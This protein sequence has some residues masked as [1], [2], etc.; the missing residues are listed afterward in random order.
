M[1]NRSFQGEQGMRILRSSGTIEHPAKIAHRRENRFRSV[2]ARGRWWAGLILAIAAAGA[3]WYRAEGRALVLPW[4]RASFPPGRTVRNALPTLLFEIDPQEVERLSARRQE[5]LQRGI[6]RR[7]DVERIAA[8]VRF[9]DQTLQVVLWLPEGPTHRWQ[10]RQW[11]LA[12]DVQDGATITDMGAFSARPVDADSFLNEWLYAQDLRDAGIPAPRLSLANLSLNGDDWGLYALRD[13]LT[14]EWLASQVYDPELLG[15]TLAHT[16][17]WGAHGLTWTHAQDHNYPATAALEP[18]VHDALPLA[19]AHAPFWDPARYEDPAVVDAYARE[20]SRISQ[21][22]YLESF[23]RTYAARFARYKAALGP[24]AEGSEAPWD[25]LADRQTLLAAALQSPQTVYAAEEPWKPGRSPVGNPPPVLPVPPSVREALARHPFLVVSERPGM[26]ALQAGTWQVKG[27]LVLPEGFGLEAAEQVTLAFER[28]AVLFAKGPLL[29]HGPAEGGIHLVPQGDRWAGLAVYGAGPQAASSLT[30]VEIRGAAG[31]RREG[32]A[33][34][35]G[36]TFHESPVSLNRCRVVDSMAPDAVHVVR[37]RFEIVQTEIGHVSGDALA[38]DEAQGRIVRCAFHDVLGD[39]IDSNESRVDVRDSYLLR[40]YDHAISAGEGS[41]VQLRN[42]RVTDVG[43]A[44]SAHSE[45]HVQIHDLHMSQAWLAGLAAYRRELAY[46]PSDI[47]A[48]RL[49]SGPNVLLP[50][51]AEPGNRIAVDGADVEPSA[52]D[53]EAL[54]WRDQATSGV[55]MLSY[56]CGEDIRLLGYRLD[57]SSGESA[58][59][60]RLVLYWQALGEIEREYTVFVHVLDAS[61]QLVAQRDSMPRDNTL[62]TTHWLPGRVIEDPHILAL[63][64][65]LEPGTYRVAVGLYHWITGERLPVQ[66]LDGEALPNGV[67]F[68]EPP[69]EIG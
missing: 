11:D 32:W 36:A 69:I 57:V 63:P 15:R 67:I 28:Q 12:V 50:V 3:I 47:Q 49:F 26:L 18:I 4:L 65:E 61:G 14:E 23:R 16:N 42:V 53:A 54:H 41:A 21:Q 10:E 40:I 46:G 24:D 56:R 52:F 1:D 35:G 29:L 6:L 59:P 25:V 68:V 39:G 30:H 7:E 37:A 60:L 31:V 33:T 2:I 44:V 9:R 5:A 20:A 64:E 45:S 34:T 17:L 19:P 8:R 27:D 48:T 22:D 38:I 51:L 13:L 66:R 43:V 55:R 58:E 62:P